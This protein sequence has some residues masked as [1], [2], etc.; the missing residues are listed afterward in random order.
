M[1]THPKSRTCRS[2]CAWIDGVAGFLRRIVSGP[3][4]KSRRVHEKRPDR[5]RPRSEDEID[6]T[7]DASFPASDPPSWSG[8]GLG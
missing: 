4:P 3:P 1:A 5:P 8:S 7:A 6:Q 2:G